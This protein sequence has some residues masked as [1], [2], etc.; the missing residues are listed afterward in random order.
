M[1][2]EKTV[3]SSQQIA[4]RVAELA[5]RINGDYAGRKLLVVGVLTGAF[6]FT[7]DLVRALD[8]DLAVDFIQVSSYGRGTSSSGEITLGKDLDY[9][10][11]N[12]EV[13]LVEDIIDT[14]RTLTWLR[15]HL[16]ARRPASF[17]V[18]ALLDKRERREVE[19]EIDYAGFRVERGFLV[20]YGLD[21]A[22]RYRQRP[23]ILELVRTTRQTQE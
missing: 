21:Y 7:A 16:F 2:A 10:I 12:R 19:V 8:L 22:G 17:K 15:H 6:I 9:E 23:E 13:L 11:C 20:G 1:P 5:H 4:T 3:F 18:C 14:G